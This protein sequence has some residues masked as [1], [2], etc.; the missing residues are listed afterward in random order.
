MITLDEVHSTGFLILRRLSVSW[1]SEFWSNKK[2]CIINNSNLCLLETIC[3]FTQYFS[4]KK[5]VLYV[6]IANEPTQEL[7]ELHYLLVVFEL[8]GQPWTC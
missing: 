1:N 3:K 5:F 2:A 6:S 7:L 4:C 8:V